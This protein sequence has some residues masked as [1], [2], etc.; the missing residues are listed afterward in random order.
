MTSLGDQS[1]ISFSNIFYMLHVSF[2]NLIG[3]QFIYIKYII[4]KYFLGKITME[5]KSKQQHIFTEKR[6]EQFQSHNNLKKMS[7]L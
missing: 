7:S 4:S 1:P 2:M 6:G 5:Y 3:G